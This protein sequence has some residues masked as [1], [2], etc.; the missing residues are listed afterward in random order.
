MTRIYKATVPSK[1]PL[2]T[3]S[4]FVM[5]C[6][7]LT[8]TCGCA[9]VLT[10]A[11]MTAGHMADK[12]V[13]FELDGTFANIH[14]A[15][16]FALESYGANIV[17]EMEEP[18]N[19]KILAK[20]SSGRITVSAYRIATNRVRINILVGYFGDRQKARDIKN[21]IRDYLAG[22]GIDKSPM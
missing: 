9:P 22:S 8:M 20:D 3:A 17:K 5:M 19:L 12:E 11:A 13:T 18:L 4:T 15:I 14:P 21:Y 16:I 10:G 2:D 6:L 1:I 7:L